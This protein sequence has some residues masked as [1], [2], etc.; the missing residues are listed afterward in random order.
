M[1][2]KRKFPLQ[3]LTESL[4]YGLDSKKKYKKLTFQCL[5]SATSCVYFNWLPHCI[6]LW[7]AGSL[8]LLHPAE[9]KKNLNLHL[10]DRPT[11]A[12]LSLLCT[13]RI[14]W[15]NLSNVLEIASP[16]KIC[17]WQVY[18]NEKWMNV[19]VWIEAENMSLNS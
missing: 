19:Q 4:I 9:V 2:L 11:S 15:T 16:D 18:Q 10:S 3:N 6:I 14:S 17:F 12:C 1:P 13:T 7:G 8:L 5:Y